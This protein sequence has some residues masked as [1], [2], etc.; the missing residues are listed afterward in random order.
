MGGLRKDKFVLLSSKNPIS[1]SSVVALLQCMAYAET[2]KPD[3]IILEI[4]TT[5]VS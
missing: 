5:A 3:M 1:W 2:T 4:K